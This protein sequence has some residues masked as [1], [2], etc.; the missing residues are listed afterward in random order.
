MLVNEIKNGTSMDPEENVFETM[1]GEY[2]RVVLQ[3]LVSSFGLDFLV[4]DQY[5]GDVDTIENVRKIDS[6][7]LMKYK[8]FENARAYDSLEKYN[9]AEYHGHPEFAKIK[10]DARK[11]F[12]TEGKKQMDAYVP[13][14][15]VIP[16]NNETIPRDKQGQLDHVI[17]AEKVH[18]D[19]GR[20]LAELDGIE[21][22]NNPGNL[23]FTN[24]SLNLNKSNMTADE[25]IQWCENNPDKVNWNGN[26]GEALPDDVKNELRREYN[27]AKKEYDAKLARAYYTSP[28]FAKDTAAAAGKKGAQMALRQALGFVFVEVWICARDELKAVP[29]ESDFGDMLNAIGNGIKKGFVSAGEKYKELLAKIKEGFVAGALSSLTTTLCNIFFTTAKNLVRCIRQLYASVIQA[30]R[31][32]LFNP[33]NLMLGDRV[34]AAAVIMA[35]GASVLVGTA[36]GDLISKTPIGAVPVI[37]EVVTMFCSGLVSGLISCSLVVFLDRSKFINKIVD[38]LNAIPSEVNNFR[39][40]ADAMES[41]AAKL[42][43]IDIGQFREDTAKYANVATEIE[44]CDDENELNE[45]LLS[46]YKVIGVKIPWDGDFDEFMS[47]RVNKLVFE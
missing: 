37:G 20:V 16:R 3:S 47:D 4:K 44:K 45:L 36:V 23:R 32:L 14:N 46:T 34:K 30:G 33:D 11:A 22:A 21:L 35:T 12:D 29:A 9:T 10:K 39:E 31:V 17:P 27:R 2:E 25:Y 28:K 6:D 40:I 19:R 38:G 26:K 43:N 13:G 8:N 1:L 18:K 42:S 7:P 5:G 24:A 15:E 41:L